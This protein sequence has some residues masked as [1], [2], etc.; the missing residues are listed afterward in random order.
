M[1]RR[2]TASLVACVFA[3]TFF[4]RS[5][6]SFAADAPDPSAIRS[7]IV[8]SLPLIEAGAR[9]AMENRKQC[10]TC[11]NGGV[12]IIALTAAR[13]RGFAIDAKNLQDLLQFADGIL[14]K[15]RNRYLA[16][17]GQ[18]GGIVTAGYA[19]WAL[20]AGGTKASATTDA[21]TEYLL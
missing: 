21:V 5:I 1:K 20:D 14:A 11:H 6:D 16:G 8:K 13:E 19:L 12:P 15:N 10:F 9:G 18:G 4:I 2:M 7:A 17:T 3:L